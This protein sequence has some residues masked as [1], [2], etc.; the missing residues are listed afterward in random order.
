MGLKYN[1]KGVTYFR[2][3]SWPPALHYNLFISFSFYLLSPDLPISLSLSL[4]FSFLRA[5]YTLF[6]KEVSQ[7]LLGFS[8]RARLKD[9]NSAA[10]F[11][12]RQREGA[13][14]KGEKEKETVA[15]FFIFA[16]LLSPLQ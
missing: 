5:L 10:P 4:S 9:M 14:E 13:S 8:P 15:L 2:G 6:L 12:S 16:L 7:L 3:V 1:Q 11:V